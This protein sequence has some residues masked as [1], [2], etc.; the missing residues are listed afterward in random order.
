APTVP[1]NELPAEP[2]YFNGAVVPVDAADLAFGPVKVTRTNAG[3]SLSVVRVNTGADLNNFEMHIMAGPAS[4]VTL[5]YSMPDIR[6]LKPGYVP[7]V[8]RGINESSRAYWAGLLTIPVEKRVGKLLNGEPL[9]QLL[10]IC[11]REF[12]RDEGIDRKYDLYRGLSDM[13]W[14]CNDQERFLQVLVDVLSGQ[15][16]I[17][18]ASGDIRV[19][20][21]IREANIPHIVAYM[22]AAA[23]NAGPRAY[24]IETAAPAFTEPP[25]TA[26]RGTPEYV[27]FQM[28]GLRDR[29]LA[30]ATV[31]REQ[32]QESVDE[33]NQS[34]GGVE[35]ADAGALRS[36][37]GSPIALNDNT[38]AIMLND[39]GTLGIY[40][41]DALRK[42]AVAQWQGIIDASGA[43]NEGS[44]NRRI[45]L[46][47]YI[48]Q[49]VHCLNETVPEIETADPKEWRLPNHLFTL[50]MNGED[51][52][53]LEAVTPPT[54]DGL[55]GGVREAAE[56]GRWQEVDEACT[57]GAI[58]Q[59]IRFLTPENRT[60]LIERINK[61][62]P[63]TT[64]VRFVLGPRS[65]AVENLSQIEI[66]DRAAPER[67]TP[68]ARD[69]R[70]K[71]LFDAALANPAA[72]RY[73][74]T[75][76]AAI[77]ALS[78]DYVRTP[79]DERAAF[80]TALNARFITD[81]SPVRLRANGEALERAP[82]VNLVQ[83]VSTRFNALVAAARVGSPSL[84]L[85]TQTANITAAIALLAPHVASLEGTGRPGFVASLNRQLREAG[86]AVQLRLNGEVLERGPDATGVTVTTPALVLPEPP[87]AA[88]YRESRVLLR[89]F[90]QKRNAENTAWL[91][92]FIRIDNPSGTVAA[93][94]ELLASWGIVKENVDAGLA[95]ESYFDGQVTRFRND[96]AGRHAYTYRFRFNR[97]GR[98]RMSGQTMV[99]GRAG[100]AIP[101]VLRNVTTDTSD[102]SAVRNILAQAQVASPNRW[103]EVAGAAA[104]TRYHYDVANRRLHSF[105][106][107]SYR[108]LNANYTWTAASTTRP[109]GIPAPG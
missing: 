76:T 79:S 17:P 72:P 15:Q 48:M 7:T 40:E 39:A 67:V 108:T 104:G 91:P 78:A 6:Y 83:P 10:D 62:L 84:P 80:V 21:V 20:G 92:E 41:L 46:L 75:L 31:T 19:D 38:A 56:G 82:D 23:R 60:A 68:A 58:A 86:T 33:I 89:M 81:G 73:A 16:A 37:V 53:S 52:F 64:T 26:A 109:S 11:S 98:F 44:L 51:A 54:V 27:G 66:E 42:G 9:R 77:T 74:E 85:A 3:R 105:D 100:E 36:V 103:N 12:N 99:N 14:R 93:G 29:V 107:T 63:L 94:N 87:E 25:E 43:E 70:R 50:R 24:R 35:F 13:Y 2:L 45:E 102:V 106:G 34:I 18:G 30:S 5:G 69:A 96:T 59:N 61:A 88:E 8:G 22:G 97:A 71:T 47:Q 49:G 95:L 65:I 28:R 1:V 4:I 90:I 32:L 55:F 57:T 101:E